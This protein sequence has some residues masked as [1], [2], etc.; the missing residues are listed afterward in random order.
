MITKKADIDWDN[1]AATLKQPKVIGLIVGVVFLLSIGVL[2]YMVYA[3][4]KPA[5]I[6][7]EIREDVRGAIIE[8][9]GQPLQSISNPAG[10]FII[11]AAHDKAKAYAYGRDETKK[12]PTYTDEDLGISIKHPED[13]V[14]T[15]DH[16]GMA[17]FVPSSKI[18]QFNQAKG[19]FLE[20][21]DPYWGGLGIGIDKVS[22]SSSLDN[23]IDDYIG[24]SG[25]QKTI[26]SINDQEA[27][28]VIDQ[29]EDRFGG[30]VGYYYF[31]PR[32]SD[33]IVIYLDYFMGQ[34]PEQLMINTLD[35]MVSSLR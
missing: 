26:I 8:K 6:P 25:V 2:V 21:N 4:D 32:H 15:E 18:D 35:E 11:N 16:L 14:A 10:T 1:F 24:V 5:F 12:W 22:H 3:E 27:T 20:N 31:V 29:G 34:S 17:F 19:E 30:G 9:I 13:W 28:K 7:E 33:I 23:F